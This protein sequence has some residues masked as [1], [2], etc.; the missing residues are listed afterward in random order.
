MMYGDN[1]ITLVLV[2]VVPF[3]NLLRATPSPPWRQTDRQEAALVTKVILFSLSR[4]TYPPPPPPFLCNPKANDNNNNKK[5]E[6]GTARR[7]RERALQIRRFAQ[8]DISGIWTK[9]SIL[10]SLHSSERILVEEY[11]RMKKTTAYRQGVK[12]TDGSK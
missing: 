1:I 10:A 4:S 11:R 6:S 5:Q 2:L 8:I 9:I 12:R 3:F 7:Q